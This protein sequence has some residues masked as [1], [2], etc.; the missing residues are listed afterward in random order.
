MIDLLEA[1]TTSD[2]QVKLPLTLMTAAPLAFAAL[3]SADRVVTVVVD[4]E[5][6]PVVEPFTVAYPCTVGA[7]SAVTAVKPP[8]ARAAATAVADSTA[9]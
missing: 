7:A 2:E 6:P 1:T 5:A 8:T 3:V 4:P 9:M